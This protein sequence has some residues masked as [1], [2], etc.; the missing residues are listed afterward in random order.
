MVKFL[1]GTSYDGSQVPVCTYWSTESVTDI[2]EDVAELESRATTG[3]CIANH[4]FD[5]N[6]ISCFD[7]GQCNGE[8]KCLSCTKYRYGAGMRMGISHSPPLEFLREF[9]H[10]LTDSDLLSPQ[11]NAGGQP[12]RQVDQDQ[13]PFHIIVRNV[14]AEIAKCCRW[15]AGDGAA[16]Q[17]L[18]TQI[19]DGPDQIQITG[20]NGGV[21]VLKGI[22]VKNAAFPQ[23]RGNQE[24][25][26]EGGSFFAVGTVVVAGWADAPSFYLEPRTG[27]VKPGEGVVFKSATDA[28]TVNSSA[29]G[30]APAVPA[31]TAN[32]LSAIDYCVSQA[33]QISNS[34]LDYTINLANSDAPAD[35]VAAAKA[36]SDAA[37]AAHA[38][39]VAAATAAAPLASAANSSATALLAATT[40]EGIN[41]TSG[42]CATSLESLAAQVDIA[43]VN[44]GGQPASDTAAVAS[45]SLRI[46]AQG[47]RFA[48]RGG[49]T[50]CELAITDENSAAQWNSPEDGTLPCNG[51]RSDCEF[52]SG[53]EWKFATT[54]KLEVGQQIT[55]EAVQ[56]LRFY[57]DDWSRFTNPEAVFTQRFTTPFVWAFKDFTNAGG[58]PAVADMAIYRPLTLMARADSEGG[59]GSLT[60]NAFETMRV[61]KVKISNFENL[62]FQKTVSRITP[63]SRGGAT[64]SSDSSVEYAD[65]IGKLKVPA[66]TRLKI[67]HPPTD[68]PFIY[69]SWTPEFTNRISMF[70][71]STPGTVIYLVNNTAL[72]ER[73]RYNTFFGTKNMFEIP[74]DGLPGASSDFTGISSSTL[75]PIFENLEKEKESNQSPAVLGFDITSSATGGFWESRVEVDLVHDKINDIYA[76]ILID[77]FSFIFDKVQVDCRVMHSI[78]K[79]DSFISTDFT[80]H[81]S[82]G[83][84]TLGV[85]TGELQKKAI[86]TASPTV[87]LGARESAN[88]EYGY[89]AW[90]FLDR[91]LRFSSLSTGTGDLQAG[92]SGF[93]TESDASTF[94][95]NVTYRVVQYRKTETIEN[96]Y[97]LQDCGLIMAAIKDP[98]VSRVMPLASSSGD[99][100]ALSPVLV[101]N[102]ATGSVIAPWAPEKVTLTVDGDQ[103]EMVLIY[104]NEEGVGLPANYAI[105]GPGIG[106]ENQFGRPDPATDSLEIQYTY[107]RAQ[108]HGTDESPNGPEGGGTVVTDNFYGD[109]TRDQGQKITIDGSGLVSGS[110]SVRSETIGFDQQDFVFVFSDSDRRPIGKKHCRFM[111]AYYNLACVSVEIF[112]AWR[113]ICTTYALFPDKLLVTGGDSGTASI[114]CKATINPDELTLGHLVAELLGPHPCFTTPNCAD[115]EILR[116]GPIRKEFETIITETEGDEDGDGEPDE[117]GGEITTILKAVYP[118][119]G[120]AFDASKI[121]QSDPPG[122]QWQKKRGTLWYPYTVCEKPRYNTHVGSVGGGQSSTELINETLEGAGTE[123]GTFGEGTFSP[124]P[125]NQ[126]GL[127]DPINET[128]HIHDEVA[129][130]ILNVHSTL[131]AC[132][133][134]YTYGNTVSTGGSF[135]TGYGR[136]RGE[137][138][139]FWYEGLSWSPPPFGNF[140]RPVLM[141][142]ISSK[143]GDYTPKPER[144]AFRWMPM[145]P[146]REDL[147]A[148]NGVFGESL[149][150]TVTRLTG[151]VSPLGGVAEVAPTAGSTKYT[152]T[153]LITNRGVAGEYPYV[154]YYPTFLPDG[155]LGKEPNEQ[156]TA[157][158]TEPPRVPITTAWAW[159]DADTPISRAQG[160]TSAIVGMKFLLPD[161]FLDNRRMEVRLRPAEGNYQIS[162][163]AP[164]YDSDGALTANATVQLGDGPPREIEIDFINRKF[165]PAVMPDTVYD[166]SKILGDSPFPCTPRASS[167]LQL[168]SECSC[169]GNAAPLEEQPPPLP[170]IFIH[171]DQI[172]PPAFV[173]LYATSTMGPA[174][175]T[176]IPREIILQPCCMCNY[177]LE[178]IYFS[179]SSSVLP[180]DQSFDPALG[181]TLTMQYTWS[182]VPHGLA[183]AIGAGHDAFDATE[184]LAQNYLE[185]AGVLLERPPTSLNRLPRENVNAYFPSTAEATLPVDDVTPLIRVRNFSDD[186]DP[187]LLGGKP[188][189][190][191]LSKGEDEQIT[192]DFTFNAYTKIKAV[193]L[194]FLAGKGMQVPEVLLLGIPEQNRTGNFVTTRSGAI[195][196]T[197]NSVATGTVVPDPTNRFASADIQSG[198]ALFSASIIPG[199]AN[200][201]FW[202]Q[203]FR[204]FHLVFLARDPTLSMGLHS[205]ELI[206][207]SL[208]ATIVETIRIPERRYAVSTF[209][210]PGGKNPE[211]NLTGMDSCSA[212]WR[213]TT[214]AALSGA[215][216]HRAYSWGPSVGR[217]SNVGQGG[218]QPTIQ[219]P[220]EELEKLQI[221]EYDKARALMER[222]YTYSFSSFYPLGE[223]KWID[224]LG[225]AAGSWTTTVSVDVSELTAVSTSSSGGTDDD[226]NA[227]P[228]EDRPLYGAVPNRSKFQAPGHCFRHVLTPDTGGASGA[229]GAG[230]SSVLGAL[231]AF[232]ENY[233][234]CCEG[235]ADAQTVSYNFA[236]LHD[237]L[238]EV[239][240][241]GFWSDFSA[242][243][244]FGS[245]GAAVPA[246]VN[247]PD[248]KFLETSNF[249][250]AN[251]QPITTDVLNASGFRRDTDGNLR[252]VYPVETRGGAL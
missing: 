11:L 121:T 209:T 211:E 190:G 93:V 87:V 130:R 8:G 32:A 56:E 18:I 68:D 44:C 110:D 207:D 82:G 182:R 137:I 186:N 140:G 37:F 214:T 166:S 122:T 123:S 154:P 241:A 167:N 234:P 164:E 159:R 177:F 51:M 228:D 24:T 27:L 169:D 198:E 35:Q 160:D 191:G 53:P 33:A 203:F 43:N 95:V 178:H 55:A 113:G 60:T 10:G 149:E 129:A 135:F 2:S 227:L 124:G 128:H 112:Y 157:Q 104:R 17:F 136:K 180:V 212:Y 219:L 168:A 200:S 197:S 54:E 158:G 240:T 194:T 204:E 199:Y 76:F 132:N 16:S 229:G 244:S 59:V 13:T 143:I 206:V 249:F 108:S 245:I 150:P 71:S 189:T 148:T 151:V 250:D 69:R 120:Q 102:G 111:V 3:R 50:N 72:K 192:L 138:D 139:Q 65:R 239:E 156:G 125:G 222:P 1:T 15:S 26:P 19:I 28:G 115:H 34:K 38:A 114:P 242:G 185:K 97:L 94:I 221:E 181:T 144:V 40:Q 74:S 236:H 152:H 106:S 119:A 98:N 172:S 231:N 109:R 163:T 14:Q 25:N 41:S 145:F 226:G 153:A 237:G 6:D 52:Y 195:L 208:T 162:Y 126:G 215:N 246:S 63:G 7:D 213:Q 251:G 161:Y 89:Y 174:F 155:L 165:G 73:D 223:Q 107:L 66:T 101:N 205:V 232:A 61:E 96:W 247:N 187:K 173:A 20:A 220:I 183:G 100:K 210:P 12:V 62:Q 45:R 91:G 5:R 252:I 127:L 230:D 188:A 49:T 39:C 81:D 103:K 201:P 31:Q 193:N 217:E 99:F 118:S 147:G 22:R 117:E 23:D 30:L 57:S 85:A 75:F 218:G 77:N 235:C 47:L 4:Y 42:A 179:L 21:Q 48:S 171:G 141:V 36:I 238:A 90:Q 202:D 248:V 58:F 131:R 78:M 67:T 84:S 92:A 134:S 64:A 46:G 79:Q 86:L 224:F 9:N 29:K 70:G 105:Y 142:E 216:R 80:I 116:L 196:G 133:S 170:A 225:G 175:P 88:L 184:N 83:G 243:P 233:F 146:Q 176:D